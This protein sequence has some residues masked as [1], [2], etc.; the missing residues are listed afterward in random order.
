MLPAGVIE[1]Q[2]N[3]VR[4]TREADGRRVD[5]TLSEDSLVSADEMLTFDNPWEDYVTAR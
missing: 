3:L 2:D 4:A 1:R 5:A